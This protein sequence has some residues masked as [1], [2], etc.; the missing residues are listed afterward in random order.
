MILCAG[1]Q[2]LQHGQLAQRPQEGAEE[3]RRGRQEGGIP[4]HRPADQGRVLPGGRE[5]DPDHR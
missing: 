5:H 2:D 3:G 1:E 4:L